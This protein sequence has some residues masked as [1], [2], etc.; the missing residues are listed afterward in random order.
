MDHEHQKVLPI[1]LAALPIPSAFRCSITRNVMEDP[2]WTVDE[3]VFERAALEQ[4][5]RLGH[6]TNPLTNEQ[7]PSLKLTPDHPL[8]AAIQE[9]LRLRPEIAR[10][11]ADLQQAAAMVQLRRRLNYPRKKKEQRNNFIKLKS[12]KFGNLA[13]FSSF[14][15]FDILE[16]FFLFQQLREILKI[17]F[18]Y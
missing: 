13:N 12:G 1:P 4:W 17:I 10:P 5:F 2:V 14:T 3:H 16:H 8:R 11:R 9:Y 7:L 18:Y 15:M 6:R